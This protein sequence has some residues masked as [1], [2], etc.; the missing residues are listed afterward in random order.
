MKLTLTPLL[1]YGIRFY[2][3]HVSKHKGFRCA[4]AARHDSHS[5][6][7]EVR[8]LLEQHPFWQALP[9]IHQRFRACRA[10][11]QQLCREDEADEADKKQPQKKQKQD[12]CECVSSACNL[13]DFEPCSKV[14][15]CD[16]GGC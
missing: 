5:C 4:Y 16:F 14:T 9:K 1:L 8:Y 7:W 6:S 15:P 2:Q 11:Y 3:R 12:K 10:A 13:P